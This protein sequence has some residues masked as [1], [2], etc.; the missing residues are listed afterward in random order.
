MRPRSILRIVL[1]L[2]VIALF[3]RNYVLQRDIDK[4]RRR[5]TVQW[6]DTSTFGKPS[7]A[8]TAGAR[9][10][11]KDELLGGHT[12][13]RHVGRTDTELR[14][15]LT[16]ERI[17]AASTYTDRATAEGAVGFA[18]E[19]KKERI[20]AWLAKAGG[21]PNLVIDYNSDKPL[22][23]TLPRGETQSEPCAHAVVVLKFDPPNSYHVVTSYPQCGAA[24][25]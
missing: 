9:D 4:H 20:D 22:G 13:S 8:K 21:H 24:G 10:L 1:V 16:K 17:S 6:V 18:L 12:L 7:A 2:I 19:E 5:E 11:S 25:E 23:R 15:R 14:E 3:V